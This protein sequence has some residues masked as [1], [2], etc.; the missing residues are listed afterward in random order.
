MELGMADS[1]YLSNNDD[2]ELGM[3][4]HRELGWD[5]SI[6]LGMFHYRELGSGGWLWLSSKVHMCTPGELGNDN[7]MGLDMAESKDLSCVDVMDL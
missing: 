4:D 1:R 2:I 6:E 5:D 7:G 3:G